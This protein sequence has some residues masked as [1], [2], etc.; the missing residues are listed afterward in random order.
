MV[1]VT[2][3]LQVLWLAEDLTDVIDAIGLIQDSPVWTK[4]DQAG[5]YHGSPNT[6]IGL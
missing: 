3:I 4:E 1:K 5:L 6:L 2:Y